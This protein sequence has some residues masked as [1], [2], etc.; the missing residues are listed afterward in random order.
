MFCKHDA[1]CGSFEV[2]GV[3]N[4]LA[5]PNL[6]ASVSSLQTVENQS[7]IRRVH[8]GMDDLARHI[9]QPVTLSF[10]RKCLK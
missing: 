2:A 4:L 7:K 3:Q 10:S 9:S 8:K 1:I 6:I 5:K